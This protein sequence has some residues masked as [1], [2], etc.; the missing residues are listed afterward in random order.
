M[1]CA[2]LGI[3]RC[4][5][6]MSEYNTVSGFCQGCNSGPEILYEQGV[7]SCR[8]YPMK[9][10]G[11]MECTDKNDCMAELSDGSSLRIELSSWYQCQSLVI[12][13][14]ADCRVLTKL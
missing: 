1:F 12:K 9:K 14:F 8:S 2:Q 13:L 10:N 3:L 7:C 11:N 6:L 5:F 4:R